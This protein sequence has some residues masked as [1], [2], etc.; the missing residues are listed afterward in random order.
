M[1]RNETARVV[2]ITMMDESLRAFEF[3]GVVETSWQVGNSDYV[4]NCL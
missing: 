4:I 1:Q 3:D 2:L